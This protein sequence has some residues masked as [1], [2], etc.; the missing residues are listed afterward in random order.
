MNRKSLLVLL[1]FGALMTNTISPYA[2]PNQSVTELENEKAEIQS[3]KNQITKELEDIYNKLKI[4][5]EEIEKIQAIVDNLQS[6]LDSLEAN[7]S[8]LKSD[9]VSKEEQILENTIEYE[10][11]LEEESKQKDILRERLRRNYIN[12]TYND[13]LAIILDST[14]L[15]EVAQKFKIITNIL[16]KDKQAIKDMQAAQKA[17]EDTRVTLEIDKKELS[18]KRTSLEA[19]QQSIA[20]KQG[21]YLSQKAVLDEEFKSL[22]NI[23]N[24]KQEKI[25]YLESREQKIDLDIHNLL[26]PPEEEEWDDSITTTDGIYG[27]F[28]K[29]STGRLTSYFGYRTDPITGAAGNNHTGLDIANSF[30]TPVRA[31]AAGRVTFSGWNSGGY[32]KFVIIDHGN[33]VVTR[34]AHNQKLLVDVGD[35]VTQ[36]QQIA[37]MGSTGYSTGSHLHFE[38]KVNGKFINPLPV[39][40]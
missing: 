5:N 8:T 33:G 9:I 14:S 27:M 34:Y 18:E 40:K 37:E 7:I 30:G 22:E 26:H 21:V 23:E 2:A 12:N 19:T 25:K 11:K 13:F 36:G 20:E 6:E 32:G 24:I 10:K 29:P 28:I 1:V 3:E 31:A 35:Y 38:I 16:N 17:L 39:Y 4:K 15:S